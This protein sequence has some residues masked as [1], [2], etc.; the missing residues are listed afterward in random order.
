V[1]GNFFDN[2]A[3]LQAQAT[4]DTAAFGSV[5]RDGAVMLAAK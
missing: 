3:A 2:L 1:P 4:R 5:A